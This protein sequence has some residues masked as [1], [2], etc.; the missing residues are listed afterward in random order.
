MN[1]VIVIALSFALGWFLGLPQ[2]LL[3]SRL[4][5]DRRHVGFPLGLR[6]LGVDPPLQ[7]FQALV[8]ALLAIRFGLS[9]QL[10]IYG[11]L[12]LVLTVVL[13]V[14]LRTRFVHG[15]VA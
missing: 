15:V 8:L 2:A 9:P 10:A 13:F 7:G 5:G 1:D 14:D 6:S 3:A 11:A 12:S 4:G